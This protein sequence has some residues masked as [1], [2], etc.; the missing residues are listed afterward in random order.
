[1][2]FGTFCCDLTSYFEAIVD[3]VYYI[4]FCMFVLFS[5]CCHNKLPP[6][7]WLKTILIYYLIVLEARSLKWVLLV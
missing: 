4:L 2:N 7:Y 3:I 5:C 6:T 1:M